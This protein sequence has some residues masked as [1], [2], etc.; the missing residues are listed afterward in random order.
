MT[1]VEP[2]GIIGV[3]EIAHAIVSGLCDGMDA[4]PRILLSPRGARVGAELAGRHP[5]VRV[6]A[7]NQAVADEAGVVVIAVRPQDRSEALTSL[8]IAPGTVVISLMAGVA[9][10]ELRDLLGHTGPVIRAIPLPAVSRRSSITVTFPEHPVSE[11]LFG[12]LGGSL[13]APAED[14]F[15]VFSALTSTFTSHYAYLA[16]LAAW[17]SG[18]GLEEKDADRYVR[19]L[20]RN[21]A[22]P[23]GDES[24]D[25]PQIAAS[26][27]TPGGINERI[28]TTWFDPNRAALADA[29]DALLADLRRPSP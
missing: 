12:T 16:T 1:A 25:L 23:L 22:H 28:R 18:Q 3:G 21:V 10:D 19:D 8:A 26:H 6:C 29:L 7:D 11:A 27:E 2:I 9:I 5:N 24:R 15:D 14:A 20:F 17:A 13:V 4:P